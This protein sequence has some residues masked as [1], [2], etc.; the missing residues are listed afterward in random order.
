MNHWLVAGQGDGTRSAQPADPG[1][2][3]HDPLALPHSVW[4]KGPSADAAPGEL[5]ERAGRE[6]RSRGR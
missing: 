2:D 6:R 3:D 1:A 5:T 4:P